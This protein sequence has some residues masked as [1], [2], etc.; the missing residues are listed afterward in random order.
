MAEEGNTQVGGKEL[1]DLYPRVG[2]ALAPIS[3]HMESLPVKTL[4]VRR[5][6]N[7]RD[8][9]FVMENKDKPFM[10]QHKA[11]IDNLTLKLYASILLVPLSLFAN[12]K[13][14][15]TFP[16]TFGSKHPLSFLLDIA[17]F[18]ATAYAMILL[19]EQAPKEKRFQ[20]IKDSLLAQHNS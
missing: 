5:F 11:Y 20:E 12:I 4:G 16:K 18:S 10:S 3:K 13:L 1:I 19:N 7:M 6:V 9:K 8:L 14:Q 15:R 2:A 17:W